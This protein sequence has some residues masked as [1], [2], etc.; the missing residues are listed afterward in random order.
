[1]MVVGI[2]GL[3]QEPELATLPRHQNTVN[4]QMT[5]AQLGSNKQASQKN[6]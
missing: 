3:D 4:M 5:V 1:M 2:A 6:G